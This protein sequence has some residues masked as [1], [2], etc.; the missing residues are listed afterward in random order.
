MQHPLLG[1]NTQS[2]RYSQILEKVLKRYTRGYHVA[3]AVQNKQD[4]VLDALNN[5]EFEWRTVPGITKET[6]LDSETV[7]KVLDQLGFQVVKSSRRT[8]DA[9]ELFTTRACF[10]ASASPLTKMLGA[11]RNRAD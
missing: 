3:E 8:R 2:E 9:Q 1:G 10:R 7:V 4:L 6:G 5:P 11:L